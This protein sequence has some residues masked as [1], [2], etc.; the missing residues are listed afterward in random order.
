MVDKVK[1]SGRFITWLQTRY[2]N[3]KRDDS[4]YRILK[5]AAYITVSNRLIQLKSSS[6]FLP[7]CGDGESIDSAN[8]RTLALK[9]GYRTR[10]IKASEY[11]PS[12][13]CQGEGIDFIA[14]IESAR[15]KAS[16]IR[17]YVIGTGEGI[18]EACRR[19]T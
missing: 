14:G 4:I 3:P 18:T 7:L 10:H 16:D 17:W 2:G 9:G 11:F 1:N 15:K 12:A 5:N 8:I 19:C 13:V 6:R